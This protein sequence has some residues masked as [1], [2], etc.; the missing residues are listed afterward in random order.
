MRTN[1]F[2]TTHHQTS[3]SQGSL[4]VTLMS[5]FHRHPA[6]VTS[7]GSS[8]SSSPWMSPHPTEPMGRRSHTIQL[9]SARIEEMPE[10]DLQMLG[11]LH[12]NVEGPSHRCSMYLKIELNST[13]LLRSAGRLD[14]GHCL[15]YEHRSDNI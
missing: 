10:T 9:Y 4:I 14:A 12:L 8:N 6:H 7:S 5:C 3:P 15:P 1:R 11:T 13:Q 2:L